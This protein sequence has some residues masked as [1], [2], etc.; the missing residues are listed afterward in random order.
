M[1]TAK[2]FS[3]G[4]I[5]AGFVLLAA[6]QEAT[7]TPP[8]PTRA[9]IQFLNF[10]EPVSGSLSTMADMHEWRFVAQA[11]DAIS[12]RTL[13]QNVTL[14]LQNAD[15]LTLAQ[16]NRLEVRVPVSGSYTVLVQLTQDGETNYELG[17]GYTDRPNPAE[18]TP[19]L[20]PE[21]VGVPTPT[22]PYANLGTFV[23]TL[24]S[25]QT[26]GATFDDTSDRHVY[27]FDGTAGEFVTIQMGRVNGTVDPILTLYNPDGTAMATDDN[28]GGNRA[29]AVR[30]ILLP[31]DGIYSIEAQGDGFA[32]SYWISLFIGDLLLPITPTQKIPTP[33]P[34]AITLTPHLSTA[35]PGN[36]L[37]DHVPI[38][39]HISRPGEFD[40]FPIFAAAG[41]TLTI[42]VSPLGLSQLLPAME[43]YG[44]TG[45]LVASAASG[46]SNAGTDALVAMLRIPVTGAYVVFVKGVN[47]TTTGDYVVAYGVGASWQ[48]VR[49]GLIEPDIQYSNEVS[50]RGLRDEWTV[51]LNQGDIISIAVSPTTN[52]LDPVLE[53][54]APDGSLVAMDDNGGGGVNALI[55]GARIPVS[56]LYH[57]YVTPAN[58][59]SF[60]PYSL[61]W[62]YV[63][64][65]ATA[66]IIP[67][68]IP[69]LQ[70]DDVVPP[71]TYLFYPF[72]GH[73]GGQVLIRVVAAPG[74]TLDPVA[75]L[76]GPDGTVIAENDD[77][78]SNLNVRFY[79][80]LPEDGTYTVRVN[81]Y[82]SSGAFELLVDAVVPE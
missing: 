53:L 29:A 70:F 25:G 49:R 16:G 48:N 41:E 33:T 74:S 24:A 22:P 21:V 52:A 71:D 44:P 58:A 80:D 26:L 54:V 12:V 81:G 34:I 32:G 50:R 30:N 23:G 4:I 46:E 45:E 40:R 39:E 6:C 15:G 65:A 55:G 2:Q 42:A 79:A 20:L 51:F 35:I 5:L 27:I 64:L 60:G 11:N 75:A 59:A 68:T 1:L 62:H 19:T 56:G 18:R 38:I 43:I 3:C 14:T 7:P 67:A 63:N 61:I 57:I 77:G 36:R 76:L 66:T 31:E 47:E 17:L 78:G 8:L 69:V 28:S 9:S 73:A 82:L 13:S 72:Q 10:W 37:E